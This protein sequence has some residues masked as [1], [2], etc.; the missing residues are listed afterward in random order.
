MIRWGSKNKHPKNQHVY[1]ETNYIMGSRHD[2]HSRL[3]GQ[4]NLEDLYR[5][6]NEHRICT[7]TMNKRF[8]WTPK[9]MKNF[10]TALI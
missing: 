5:P 9:I 1:K 2:N 4:H 6:Y 7:L 10:G 3:N 8:I